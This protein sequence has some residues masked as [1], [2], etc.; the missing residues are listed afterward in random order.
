MFNTHI[1]QYRKPNWEIARCW[2]AGGTVHWTNVTNHHQRTLLMG[3]NEEGRKEGRKDER[4]TQSQRMD[5]GRYQFSIYRWAGKEESLGLQF[6][7]LCPRVPLSI[8]SNV[9]RD[10]LAPL[11]EV[12]R[13]NTAHWRKHAYFSWFISHDLLI[14]FLIII[15]INFFSFFYFYRSLFLQRFTSTYSRGAE[16]GVGL[17]NKRG[18]EGEGGRGGW[19][20]QGGRTL[21]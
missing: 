19:G 21:K 5:T 2:F 3:P 8:K 10:K 14:F 17:R 13:S 6:E 11:G 4:S 18:R 7:I 16:Q 12:S 1:I 20:R 15:F 9:I